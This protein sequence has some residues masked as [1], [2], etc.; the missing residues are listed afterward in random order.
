MASDS[1]DDF[2]SPEAALPLR[3]E[4]SSP[5]STSRAKK[6][7]I[8]ALLWLY[9]NPGSHSLAEVREGISWGEGRED[10]RSFRLL[11]KSLSRMNAV[12]LKEEWRVIKGPKGACIPRKLF[13]IE[14]APS[15]KKI[16]PPKEGEAGHSLPHICMVFKRLSR[17]PSTP[18]DFHIEMEWSFGKFLLPCRTKPWINEALAELLS[19]GAIV[20]KNKRKN[21]PLFRLVEMP[22]SSSLRGLAPPLE[23]KLPVYWDLRKRRILESPHDS[24]PDTLSEPKKTSEVKAAEPPTR[25]F[26]A[27]LGIRPNL[28]S[29]ETPGAS[30]QRIWIGGYRAPTASP[31][32]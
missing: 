32:S 31:E 19:W 29:E 11:M 17:G 27:L 25:V 24:P 28:Q 13:F 12:N 23:A 14:L 26:D 30:L 8:K 22:S 10:A 15:F 7:T 1:T 5:N 16:T 3:M 9:W 18:M 6:A 2:E 20:W 21:V 4:N